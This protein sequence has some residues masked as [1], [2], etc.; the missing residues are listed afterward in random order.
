[1]TPPCSYGTA[2][3]VTGR[4]AATPVPLTAMTMSAMTITRS[5]EPGIMTLNQSIMS[6]KNVQVHG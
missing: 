6:T 1:M 2:G 5:G 3:A 4:M